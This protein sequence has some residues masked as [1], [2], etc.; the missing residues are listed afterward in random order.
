MFNSA[1]GNVISINDPLAS[2]VGGSD[3]VTLATNKP[4][5]PRREW[6]PILRGV[7]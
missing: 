1:N 2:T 4:Y 5:R 6:D 3:T 7:L